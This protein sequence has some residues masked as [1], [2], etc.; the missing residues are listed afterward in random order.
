MGDLLEAV[1]IAVMKGAGVNIEKVQEP[2]K[3]KIGV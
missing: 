2:V 3:L 1:A